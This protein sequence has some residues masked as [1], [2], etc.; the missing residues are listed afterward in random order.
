MPADKQGLALYLRCV[1]YNLSPL[2][3]LNGALLFPLLDAS[4]MR[5]FDDY[6]QWQRQ[7]SSKTTVFFNAALIL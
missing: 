2:G 3:V 7:S 5:I 1:N 6:Y 4:F